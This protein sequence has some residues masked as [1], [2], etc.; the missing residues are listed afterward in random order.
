[1]LF[2]DLLL[3]IILEFE[4]FAG[5]VVHD[6]ILAM[7]NQ[8][9]IIPLIP[10][11]N[12]M[13]DILTTSFPLQEYEKHIY[14]LG[15]LRETLSAHKVRTKEIRLHCAHQGYYSERLEQLTMVHCF[16]EFPDRISCHV[17]AF[18]DLW[19]FILFGLLLFR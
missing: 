15:H 8:I 4:A 13:D 14:T 10:F 17:I 9:S 11:Y 5:E 7:V 6:L 2:P 3:V 18:I 19:L 1:M 16:P 12:S